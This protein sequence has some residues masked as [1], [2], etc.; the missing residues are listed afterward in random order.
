MKKLT[1]FLI[2]NFLF[3]CIYSQEN[4][5]LKVKKYVLDNGLTVILNEDNNS[6]EVIGSIVVKAGSKNDPKDATG[7]A[8][9]FEHIMFKGT[10][11][12]GT[13]NWPNEKFY[14]D[15]ITLLYDNLYLCKDEQEK[16][17][18]QKHINKLSIK[19]AE[20]AIPNETDKILQSIGSSDLNAYTAP[21]QTVFYN[22]FPINQL[23][24]WLDIYAERFRNPVFR[25]FQSE[26]EVVYE[27]KNM[28][29]DNFYMSMF[30][31]FLKNFYR[32]HPYGQ[33]ST[34]G[35]TEHLKTPRLSKMKDF[36]NTYYVANNMALILTG[37]FKSED[38]LPI[39]KEKFSVL[40]SG[41]IPKYPIY[42]EKEF[43]GR[44]V[45]NA[46]F[47]PIPIG[48]MGL[49]GVPN[50][51]E[52]ELK[53][54]ICTMLLSNEGKTGLLDILAEENK[55]LMT[56]S[57]NYNYNDYG[58]ILI[59]FAPKI[60]VQSLS[61]AENLVLEEIEK[62]KN[63]D[64]SEERLNAI[65]LDTKIKLEKYFENQNNRND[66]I[67]NCFATNST[68][69]DVLKMPEKIDNITKN[70]IIEIAKKYFNGNY[71]MFNSK[72]G[73][74]K[75]DKIEKPNWEPIPSL[76]SKEK[77][78]FAKKTDSIPDK[79]IEPKFIDFSKD[80]SIN[81][82]KDG[83]EYY[84]T[85]NSYNDIF[86][87]IIKY[88][89]GT[90][91]NLKYHY[92]ATYMGKI[93]TQQKSVHEFNA[94][95]QNLGA[96]LNFVADKNFI[97]IKLE[98]LDDKFDETIKLLAELINTPTPIENP[99]KNIL[100]EE[101]ANYKMLTKTNESLGDVLFEFAKYGEKSD[102]INK[103]SINEV[104]K[105]KGEDLIELFKEITQYESEI[106][107]IGNINEDSVKSKILKYYPLKDNLQKQY[108]L[109]KQVLEQKEPIVYILNNPKSVQSKI[110]MFC[111]GEIADNKD[112]ALLRAFNTYFGSGMS[113]LLFQELR[114]F[115][116][117]GYATYGSYNNTYL[118][119]NKG[120]FSSFLGTQND[121]VIEGVD[122]LYSLITNM[123]E[124]PEHIDIIKKELTQ[125]IFTE[126]FNFRDL[127]SAV[128]IWKLGGYDCDP[129]IY[130]MKVYEG[131]TF[132]DITNTYEKFIKNKP[133]IIT[134]AGNFSDS[135]K[136]K[137][138]KYGKIKVVKINDIIKK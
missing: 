57:F 22:S 132:N 124:K 16:L 135:D 98:G 54:N 72:M 76:N 74:P 133:I 99:L 30:E 110:Y 89:V 65:K 90:E 9:Y 113:S 2:V 53:L 95:L 47:T 45:V 43:K 131:L 82:I 86:T 17:L 117:L 123:P 3:I 109:E 120:Y 12:I 125:K 69:D 129:R 111:N 93:G 92:A 20:F 105:L 39:I 78:I 14:L 101:K 32:N 122:A 84:Q 121:K 130:R 37:N 63:G 87:L 25:L 115:R 108:F 126:I 70:D 40:K 88:K 80:V 127:S 38:I 10:D 67:I 23:E 18:I 138:S 137:L 66:L 5:Y 28:Y 59:M 68:W 81:K 106:H 103:L 71:L 27:E 62:I 50:N 8:H 58:S 114:E 7:M 100:Q 36:Y 119:S 26:L 136:Q 34:I 15:S 35:S 118:K 31:F 44:E 73:F 19:A 64:F 6:S 13:I 116:S 51:H 4:N 11:K 107:Y 1:L 102:Y 112:R 97:T 83:V 60:L 49:R 77:S 134:I 42:E 48:I 21:E 75:K 94:S 55:I 61:K 24:K 41:E 96:N 85:K 128:S 46:K 91:K 104:K 33:Q 56:Q 29:A 52:D 79:S